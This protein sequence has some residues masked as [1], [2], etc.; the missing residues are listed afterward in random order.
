[1][2]V[3]IVFPG[4]GSQK[5]GMLSPWLAAGSPNSIVKDTFVEACDHVK[6]DLIALCDNNE[7]IH[8]TQYTQ[9]LL[10]AANV[11]LW[12]ALGPNI[13]AKASYLAGHSLGEYS[14]LVAAG[15][16][17]FADALNLVHLRGKLMQRC[18]PGAMAAILGLD[19]AAVALL[20]QQSAS[21]TAQIV[22]PANYNAPGQV[23]IAGTVD[24]I[25]HALSA[26]NAQGGK[27]IKLAVSV[28]SHCALMQDA[29]SELA[30]ALHSI[31]LHNANIPVLCN[32]TAKPCTDSATIGHNLLSQ[33]Q[34]PVLWSAS[35]QYIGAEGVDTLIECGP[36]QVLAN[37]QKRINKQTILYNTDTPE[38]LEPLEKL[39]Q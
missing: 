33:L 27:A 11:A 30:G 15:C 16:M 18:P 8:Q 9:P 36:G 13:Q 34:N 28:A 23:V 14:A 6:L 20:C 29:A 39:L 2:S 4:Q 26:A 5:L 21:A 38:K 32:V 10:L 7:L 35:M 31:T 25:N 19:D 17:R 37:L 24:A 22:A 3:A 12:R 1:M